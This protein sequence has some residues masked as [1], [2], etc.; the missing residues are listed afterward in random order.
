M[1]CNV[2]ITSIISIP[3]SGVE[4]LPDWPLCS[5]EIPPFNTTRMEVLPDWPFSPFCFSPL[6]FLPLSSILGWNYYQIGV[7]APLKFLP[8]NYYQIGHFSSSEIPKI[9]SL[10]INLF[11]LFYP[12]KWINW[13]I[14]QFFKLHPFNFWSLY[15]NTNCF[16]NLI[17]NWIN[18]CRTLIDGWCWI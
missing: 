5:S 15:Y 18:W 1:F 2:S 11:F 9:N 8:W 6:N 7:S 4:L 16:W 10:L 17:W 12:P 13:F 14:I 3:F